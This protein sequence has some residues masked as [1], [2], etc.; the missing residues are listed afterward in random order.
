MADERL[1]PIPGLDALEL[2]QLRHFLAVA[3]AL[4]QLPPPVRLEDF[5]VLVQE[6]LLQVRLEAQKLD[7][8]LGKDV[9]VGDVEPRLATHLVLVVGEFG[10]EEENEKIA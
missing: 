5:A 2:R 1:D 4:L 8:R 6:Q 7:E 9:V 10:D 3:E